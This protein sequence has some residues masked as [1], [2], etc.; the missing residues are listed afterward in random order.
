MHHKTGD[1]PDWLGYCRG[2]AHWGTCLSCHPGEE[3]RREGGGEGG[4]EERGRG[5]EWRENKW[6]RKLYSL[7]GKKSIVNGVPDQERSTC[8]LVLYGQLYQLLSLANHCSMKFEGTKV[9]NCINICSQEF[10][11]TSLQLID[12][13]IQTLLIFHYSEMHVPDTNKQIIVHI[14]CDRTH[15]RTHTRAHTHTTIMQIS[16]QCVLGEQIKLYTW[17]IMTLSIVFKL[18][19][20]EQRYLTT[21]VWPFIAAKWTGVCPFCKQIITIIAIWN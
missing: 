19:P 20:L 7:E 4:G 5:R 11:I 3:E 10:F 9:S 15:T 18:H 17:G 13:E 6:N 16:W 8:L 21:S 1:V 14:T 2:R 12:G